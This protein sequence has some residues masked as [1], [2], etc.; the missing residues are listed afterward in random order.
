MYA[1]CR[2]RRRLQRAPAGAAAHGA[3]AGRRRLLQPQLLRRDAGG[4]AGARP[5]AL[6]P[7]GARE[8]E[9]AAGRYDGA[10][11]GGPR[12]AATRPGRAGR[13]RRRAAGPGPPACRD[14]R[15]AGLE[16]RRDPTADGAA[17]PARASCRRSSGTSRTT[18]RSTRT[19]WLRACWWRRR[20]AS[21][22]PTRALCAVLLILAAGRIA[23]RLSDEQAGWAAALL[24]AIGTP[25]LGLMA[26]DRPAA[27][28]PGAPAHG[29]P[30]A[31]RLAWRAV[32]FVRGG[33]RRPL[34]AR[35]LELRARVAG[36]ARDRGGPARRRGS[37]CAAPVRRRSPR[38]FAL[39]AS[40]LAI[41]R[42]I[43]ASASSPV[44]A[45]RPRWLWL[46]GVADLARAECGAVRRAGP[47]GR[48]RSAARGAA[49]RARVSCSR[50]R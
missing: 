7:G 37:P 26:R 50:L 48:G 16:R 6:R 9:V 41:A 31:R 46:D 32:G 36:P 17:R 11:C 15:P 49:L 13:G 45:I 33:S 24:A 34:R 27:E 3:G 20:T 21:S 19:C 29:G 43:G 23:C 30:A 14:V 5:R 35:G 40:P 10:T 12:D 18:A 28:L 4:A 39:G 1:A 47:A 8:L 2:A 25:Y 38:G 44:T 42:A 22:G